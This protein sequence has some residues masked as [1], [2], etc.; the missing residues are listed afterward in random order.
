MSNQESEKNKRIAKNTIALYIRTLITMAVGLYTS[1]VVLNVLGVEDYGVYN[2]VGGVV[3][4][5]SIVTASLSQSISR[6]LTFEL[7]K[8]NQDK[9]RSIFCTSV[10]IQLLMSLVVFI[11]MECI[12]VWFLNTKMN[13]DADRMHAAN[14]VFQFSVLTFVVNLISVPYNAVIIAHEKMKAFAYVSILEAVL[15]LVIVAALLLSSIDKL[16]TYAFLQLMVSITIRMVYGSYC[17]RHFQECRYSLIIDKQ[18]I[19]DMTGFA[20]WGSTSS[21]VWIF[22]TQGI[23]IIS[24]IFFGVVV[25]A[26]RGV[27]T[28]V[29]GIV[30]GF[31][32]NFTTAVRPQIIKSYSAGDKE[33]LFKLL[34]TSTKY[35]YFLM[36]I[37]F[38]PFLFEAEAIL[39]L[40]LKKYPD[41]APLFLR[42]T[43]VSTLLGLLGDLLFTNILAVGKLKLYMISETLIT[44]FVF[45]VTYIF[46]YFGYSPAIPYVLY[47][48]AYTIL[49]IVRLFYLK[50]EERFPVKKF[51]ADVL[52]PVLLVTVLAFVVPYVFKFLIF[53][54]DNILYSIVDIF[55][56]GISVLV[57]IYLAGTNT[58]EKIFIKNKLQLVYNHLICR[59]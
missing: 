50:K 44:G 27:A 35:S 25:N 24:N 19:K 7:G 49:I 8:G 23:N 37:F 13:I 4:M 53:K 18:L 11:L 48:L 56:C 39:R 1:R 59:S 20:G 30:K 2:V 16:I 55:I 36:L 6:Y 47:A 5:F 51:W 54:S 46:F 3:S 31:V 15:K 43:L 12:G 21:I 38:V 9:L 40:W 10:N 22:N 14:W 28:Q 34:C 52:I 45:P 17:K 29:E 42:L 41:Y 58:E 33:Y 32:V 57:S 26:A